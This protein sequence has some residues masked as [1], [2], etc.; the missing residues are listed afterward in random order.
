M[1]RKRQH[2]N[3]MSKAT[4]ALVGC[5]TYNEQ[6]VYQAVEAGVELLGGLTRFVKPG[7]R[8]VL[9]PNV[10]FGSNPD[11]CVSTHPAVLKAVGRLLQQAGADVYYGDSSGFGKCEANMRRAGLKAAADELGIKL[12][13]FDNGKAVTHHEAL[14]NKQFVIANGALDCDG[15]IS[16]PKLKT[17]GLTRFTGAVK[18]QFGCIPGIR[19][20]QYH[21]KMPSPYDFAAM[22]VDLT[23]LLRPRLYIMDGIIAMEGNGPRSGWPKHMDILLFS[24]DPVALDATAC[25]IIDLN[26]EFVPTSEAGG[27]AG[28]GTYH[29]ENIALV[30]EDIES[31]IDRDFTVVRRPPVAAPGGRWRILARNWACPKPTIDTELCTSCGTCVSHCPATPK[32]VDWHTGDE[33]IPPTI[34]YDR[35]IRCY[36][37]QEFCPEGAVTIKDTLIGK[38]LFH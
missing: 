37:C 31:F 27:K 24:E 20:S 22:L 29:D 38:V 2:K 23:T 1:K 33:S 10:L 6:R 8:I 3:K 7:E 26:P 18:N 9:K 25:K 21:V 36:C 5:D 19:K 32:A 4:V 11:K 15:L 17:H 12:A 35:C 16:L 34:K 28:L 13:D 14:L 30:G